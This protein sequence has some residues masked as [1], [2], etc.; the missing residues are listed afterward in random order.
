MK[1]TFINPVNGEKVEISV[2]MSAPYS[3]LRVVIENIIDSFPSEKQA[4]HGSALVS[5]VNDMM[6]TIAIESVIYS[7]N[8]WNAMLK[9]VTYGAY[10][11]KAGENGNGYALNS[12]ATVS[13]VVKYKKDGEEI[14]ENRPAFVTYADCV[15]YMRVYNKEAKKAERMTIALP[16]DISADADAMRHIRYFIRSVNGIMSEDDAEAC[17]VRGGEYLVWNERNNADGRKNKAQT[18][19]NIF[20]A[21]TGEN[22]QAIGRVVNDVMAECNSAKS[23]YKVATTGGEVAYITALFNQ[24][25]NS[26]VHAVDR[27]RAKAPEKSSKKKTEP[28][29]PVDTM[30]ETWISENMAEKGWTRE[31]A[32]KVWAELEKAAN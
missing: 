18:I 6:K 4:E 16:H 17:R 22:V 5:L 8:I 2:S 26:N 27:H 15:K 9:K 31:Q 25:V 3:A 23:M 29:N 13:R 11:I 21:I 20:N 7:G 19:Y 1:R 32:E 24:Y 30:K 14:T 28:V 10:S 12:V